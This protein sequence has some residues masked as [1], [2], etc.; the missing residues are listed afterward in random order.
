MTGPAPVVPEAASIDVERMTTD[1]VTALA[2]ISRAT[3]WRRV[4]AGRLPKP[5]DQARQSLFLKSAVVKALAG[6]ANRPHSMAVET[7][8]RLEALRRRRL[9]KGLDSGKAPD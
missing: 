7:E 5:V 3:L 9:K 2:R 1:E 4:A 8:R 6:E